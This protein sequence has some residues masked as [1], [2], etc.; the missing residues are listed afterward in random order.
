M[1]KIMELILKNQ[2]ESYNTLRLVASENMPGISD[3]LPFMLDMFA[4]YSFD[5]SSTWKYPTYYLNDIERETCGL[6]KQMLRCKHVSLKPISG[7]NGMLTTLAAFNQIGDTVMSL[8]PNSGGHLETAAIVQKLGMKSEFLPFDKNKWKIDVEKLKVRGNLEQIRMIYIDLCMVAFPQ[9]VRELRNILPKNTVVVYD[10]SHVLGLILGDCFQNPL[11]EGAD[12]MIANTHKTFPGPHKAIFATNRKILKWQFDQMSGHFI[13]HHHMADVACLGL[14]AERFSKEGFC[15]YASKVKENTR[16]LA[17]LL[18]QSGVNVQ[19]D[20][21]NFTEC[22]QIWI[23]CGGKEQVDQVIEIC[24]KA[25]IVINGGLLP[26]L[27]GAWGIRI[28]TQEITNKGIGEEG[29]HMLAEILSEAI[30]Q[31][32][33]SEESLRKRD[34]IITKHLNTVTEKRVT[35]DLIQLLSK[36]KDCEYHG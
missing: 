5:D 17:S 18:F 9:P 32:H 6:F 24:S 26:S 12:I 15:K 35:E 8:S 3:R 16:L 10:A 31:H 19:L 29:I 27:D 13:S 28:G 2:Q 22:H 23:E 11:E 7:L 1:K 21:L 20:H 36:N 4:R 25:N 14:I 34:E 33:L 30:L